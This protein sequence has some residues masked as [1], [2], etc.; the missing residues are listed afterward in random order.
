MIWQRVADFEAFRQVA[1]QGRSFPGQDPGQP[2][3]WER[4]KAEG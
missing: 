4:L 3:F 2:M 1:E